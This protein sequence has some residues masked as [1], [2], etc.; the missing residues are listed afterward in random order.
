MTGSDCINW[1]EHWV[2]HPTALYPLFRSLSSQNKALLMDFLALIMEHSI[3]S[4]K[5]RGFTIPDF[6]HGSDWRCQYDSAIHDRGL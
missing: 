1:D 2:L 3:N 4:R 5:V 6:A